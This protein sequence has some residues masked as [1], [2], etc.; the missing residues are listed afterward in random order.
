MIFTIITLFPEVFSEFLRCSIIGR[1]LERKLV[2]VN[3]K[4]L[5]DYAHDKHRTCD[6]Y[7]FGG[8]AGMVLKAEPL[9][10]ALVDWSKEKKNCLSDS[11]WKTAKSRKSCPISS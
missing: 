1:A 8:G 2:Q 7:P 4:N 10:C 6:D 11:K 3:L 9:A 5:R